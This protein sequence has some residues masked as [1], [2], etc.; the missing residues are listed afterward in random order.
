MTPN[1]TDFKPMIPFPF[2]PYPGNTER[3]PAI[4]DPPIA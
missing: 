3:N 1:Y 2:Y 4:Q